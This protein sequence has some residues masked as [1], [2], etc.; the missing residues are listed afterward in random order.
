E[1]L[2][3]DA[4]GSAM[5]TVMPGGRAGAEWGAAPDGGVVGNDMPTLSI[6][7]DERP[8]GG[9]QADQFFPEHLVGR[10]HTLGVEGHREALE[11]RVRGADREAAD[12]YGDE[13]GQPAGRVSAVA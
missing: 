8:L 12:G 11:L 5:S 10:L 9:V 13:P 4:G 1:A 2:A 7:P 3:G 6:G